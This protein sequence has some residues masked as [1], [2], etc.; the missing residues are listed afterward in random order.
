[1]K[2]PDNIEFRKTL[3]RDFLLLMAISMISAIG[4]VLTLYYSVKYGW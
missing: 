4:I 2:T 1:M 3:K